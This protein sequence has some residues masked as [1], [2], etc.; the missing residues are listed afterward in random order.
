LIKL[1]PQALQKTA[2][3]ATRH[4]NNLMIIMKKTGFF[5]T[6]LATACIIS[7]GD[8]N[9]DGKSGKGD[10]VTAATEAQES[11]AGSSVYPDST[12]F[13][14]VIDGKETRLFVIKNNKGMSAAITN[15][16]GRIVG[17]YVPAKNDSV[18]D[19]VTG[20]KS[21]DDFVNS[22]EA[23]FGA[24]IGRYG[25]RIANGKFTLD[26]KQYTL[27]TNNGPNTLH[28]GKKGFQ[29]VVWNA[30]QENDSTLELR[31]LSKDGEEG[32]PGNLT[33]KV[34]Y[35]ITSDNAVAIAYEA[36]TDKKTVVNLTNHAFFNLNGEGSGTINNHVL[37]INA[38]QY[39][40]VDSTLIPLGKHAAVAG[41]PFDFRKPVAIGARIEAKNE[42]LKNGMGYDHNFVLRGSGLKHAA[43]ISG[44]KTGIVMD[45]YTV[46]P[47]LQFYSGNFMAAKNT[48]KSGAKDEFRTAFCLE[49]QHFPD[50]PNQPSFPTTVLN[51]GQ[52]Y[53]TNSLYRFSVK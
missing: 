33:V 15:Y 12:A 10:S 2:L 41:T 22:T 16:G 43:T 27:F 13:R 21:V 50:S 44:D 23:Y 51:P 19:V 49:T 30:V 53:K 17:L 39:T 9:S 14:K 40:P 5:L 3:V 7:C 11:A 29:A 24:T 8:N 28:G 26:G 31:Y 35:T 4:V 34:T 1:L 36:Q 20:F 47:G 46:E 32:F 38:D 25:N 48:F 42:Q 45:V 52:N 6:V 37:Q 18:V